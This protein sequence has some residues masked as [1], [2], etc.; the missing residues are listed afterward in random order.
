MRHVAWQRNENYVDKA[1]R[2]WLS[3]RY[4][5]GGTTFNHSSREIVRTED[6]DIFRN[7]REGQVVY[8][9]PLNPGT[10][11]LH[12]YFGETVVNGEGIRSVSLSINGAPTSTL[13]V[14]SDAAGAN[15][16][17]VKLFRNS[18]ARKDGLL[19]LL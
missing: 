13:D 2:V 9:I 8:E 3:G 15:T 16:A 1:G 18:S 10:Y 11:E 5:A 7:G 14:A 4:F 17:T 6:P 12:L 19:S